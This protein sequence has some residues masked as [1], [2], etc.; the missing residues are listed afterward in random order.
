MTIL[1]FY[2]FLYIV[3]PCV[4]RDLSILPHAL[5][6]WRVRGD[7]VARDG[8]SAS[9]SMRLRLVFLLVRR[10]LSSDVRGRDGHRL[11]PLQPFLSLL[12][13][14]VQASPPVLMLFHFGPCT[15]NFV[16]DPDFCYISFDLI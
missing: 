4:T 2:C 5:F 11:K 9:Q 6:K 1:I 16:S 15:F 10:V 3:G 7:G 8:L 14:K 12:H 13:V